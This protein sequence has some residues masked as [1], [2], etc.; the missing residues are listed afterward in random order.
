MYISVASNYNVLNFSLRSYIYNTTPTYSPPP[1][2]SK[3]R[4]L[5]LILLTFIL[6]SQGQEQKNDLEVLPVQV[7]L[8]K[9]VP[10]MF[11]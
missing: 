1:S 9:N 6:E 5:H 10:W 2:P 11:Y 3:D 4:N 8:K 7:S